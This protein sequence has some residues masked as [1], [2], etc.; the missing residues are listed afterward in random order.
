MDAA[1]EATR[2][3]IE[4]QIKAAMALEAGK[5]QAKAVIGVRR[6]LTDEIA[7]ATMKERDYQRF[8][9]TAAYEEKRA[10]I[11]TEITDEK[12][13]NGLLLQ[14][15][16]SHN[17]QLAALEKSFR[18]EDLQAR[19]DF[20]KEIADQEDQQT[21]DRIQN[22][23]DYF[24][25]K[26][27][28]TDAIKTMGMSQLEGER[29]MIEQEHAAKIQEIMDSKTLTEKEKTDLL[30]IWDAYYTALIQKNYSAGQILAEAWRTQMEKI[31]QW[32]SYFI[33]G[34]SDLFSQA[35]KNEQIRLDN[36]EKIK[37][38]AVNEEYETKKAAL[39]ATTANAQA[40]TDAEYAAKVKEINDN[41]KD[42]KK[43]EAMLS[44]LATKK[45]AEDENLR[46]KNAEAM[47]ILEQEKADTEARIAEDLEKKKTA[48]RR[49]AAIEEKA[50][51]LMSA[52]VNTAAAIV[53]ALPNIALAIAVGIM[54]AA[55]IALIARQ[56]IPLKEG[57][58]VTAPITARLHPGELV[59]PLKDLS[60]ALA[61]A[62]GAGPTVNV[63]A[64][65]YGDIRT[66]HDI[67]E[68]SRRLAE[69]TLQAI[70]KGRR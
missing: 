6:Q 7:K 69:R 31:I 57:G 38:E 42:E 14:A 40:A 46:V 43:R 62:G 8:A 33:S 24:A 12:A 16:Q 66:E 9:I 61:M 51:A 59:L 60:P 47:K 45:A 64:Y 50:V 34:L 32:V 3:Q 49:K 25:Q 13:K 20:A 36:E 41:I 22:E 52:I 67:D 48:L 28:V 56:P 54:G 35:T 39:D 23:K 4:A 70:S 5:E 11:K 55:Q 2:K 19:I 30:A 53:K 37:T 27:Q 58:L 18:D 1:S 17:A 68:I 29:Y 15:A 65:F 44:A 10:A 21:L 26:K 63:R